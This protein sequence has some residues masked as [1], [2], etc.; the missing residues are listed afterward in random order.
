M[1]YHI[2][3]RVGA[4]SHVQ[5][6]KAYIFGYGTYQG[7]EV[8]VGAGGWLGE[9]LVKVGTDNPKIV[10]DNGKVVW[11]CECWWTTEESVKARVKGMEVVVLDIDEERTKIRQESKKQPPGPGSRL[12]RG[13]R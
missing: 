3:D 9:M 4:I 13:T 1:G 10:L 6:G 11:G 2:G 8:P 5:D 12:E 7:D